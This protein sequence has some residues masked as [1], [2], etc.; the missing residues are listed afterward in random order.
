MSSTIVRRRQM[1]GSRV[2]TALLAT[3]LAVVGLTACGDDES[4]QDDYCAAGESL[5]SSLAAL[6]D[7]DLI[8][9]GTDGLSDAIEQVRDDLSEVRSAANDAAS[10]DVE[11]LADSVADLDSALADLGGDITSE[12]ASAVRAAIQDVGAAARGVADTLADC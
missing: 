12:N 2:G 8:A 6:A 9:T 5:Q 10:D 11:L 3:A 7:L 1:P 4:A